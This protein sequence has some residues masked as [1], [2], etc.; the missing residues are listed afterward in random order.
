VADFEDQASEDIAREYVGDRLTDR[1]YR[2]SNLY[3]IRDE[4]GK[5]VRF[6]PNDAQRIFD[7]EMW[8]R[9]VIPKARKLGFSTFIGIF[10]LDEC[11]MTS[12]STCG[13]TDRSITDAEDKLA[14]IKFAYEGMPPELRDSYFRLVRSNDKYIEWSNGSSVSVG[15]TYRG[16]TPR[17]LHVS[18]LGKVSVDT[19]EQAREI[20]TGAIQAVPQGGLVFVESTAHGTSG[21]FCDMV[22][23]AEARRIAHTPL[24]KLDFKSQFFGWMHKR[25][26][27]VPNHLVIVPQELRDYFAE[28][29]AKHGIALDADQMA[30][31]AQKH[32]ELGPDDCKQEF[33]SIPDEL[34]YSS[35][36]GAYWRK[37]LTK[38]RA[39]GRIGQL[40][41]FDPSRPVNTFWDI[42]EDCTSIW[43]HQTDGVRHRFI[44][45]YEEEGGSIQSACGVVHAK[46]RDRGFVYKKH[47]FPHDLD[48]RSWE[49]NA[50]NR[51]S[52]ATELLGDRIKVVDRID[53]KADSIEAGRRMLAMA[54]FDQ[55]HCSRG[56]ECLDNYRKQWN[57]RMGMFKSEP[58]HD[59]ASHASDAL[60]QG[61]MGLEPER[62]PSKRRSGQSLVDRPRTTAWSA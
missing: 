45:Y 38:A 10:I 9:N 32:A 31:Y 49:N 29:R 11:L 54:W 22:R 56:V 37:E 59:W 4:Q 48:R 57:D 17:I 20:M 52:I 43:F 28:L 8:F 25:E 60:Q 6:A 5:A 50:T 23:Q 27:R 55:Q 34:F 24:T 35:L 16:G 47:Y 15:L 39:E 61:A 46:A 44:D 19:P 26:Y 42:G 2:L 36:Q 30:W 53:D 14:M 12:G 3:R 21:I 58:L 62:A 41:P 51:K 40:V 18:E 33:P 13:I 7:K 1:D